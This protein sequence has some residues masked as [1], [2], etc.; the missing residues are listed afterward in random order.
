[1]GPEEDLPRNTGRR[2]R[3]CLGRKGGQT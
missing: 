2:S 1:V 3:P